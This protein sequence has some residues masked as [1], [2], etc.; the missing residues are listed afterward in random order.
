MALANLHVLKLLFSSTRGRLCFFFSE[1]AAAPPG[2]GILAHKR[3]FLGAEGQTPG[4]RR[5][6]AGVTEPGWSLSAEGSR[7]GRHQKCPFSAAYETFELDQV[8]GVRDTRRRWGTGGVTTGTALQMPG[9]GARRRRGGPGSRAKQS[10]QGSQSASGWARAAEGPPRS[11]GERGSE[12]CG[13]GLSPAPGRLR[14]RGQARGAQH[15]PPLRSEAPAP[16]ALLSGPTTERSSPDP[17]LLL[18]LFL[19]PASFGRKPMEAP[20]YKSQVGLKAHGCALPAAPR[21]H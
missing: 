4:E 12:R 17:F 15:P 8:S 13:G 5:L 14:G 10:P 6:G 11:G 3:S 1:A 16:S 9:R 7:P 20:T 18:L 2:R 21:P 19:P